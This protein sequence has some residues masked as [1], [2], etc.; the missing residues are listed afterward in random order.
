[1]GGQLCTDREA[2]VGGNSVGRMAVDGRGDE[3]CAG[4]GPGRRR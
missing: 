1:M 2:G 3:V 4:L